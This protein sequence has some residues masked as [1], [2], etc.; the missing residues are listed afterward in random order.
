MSVLEMVYGDVR[1]I[2]SD[3]TVTKAGASYDPTTDVVQ[4]AFVPVG[5][6]LSAAAW[7]TGSWETVS[8]VHTAR[9]LVAAVIGTADVTLPLGNYSA[10]YK[11][12]DS[13]E[14]PRLPCGSI[15][16]QAA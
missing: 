3:C 10:Y 14:T 7:T 4:W 1:Y 15:S 11:V 2:Y 13:P 8:G 9:I 5:G 6:T 16:V 12:A